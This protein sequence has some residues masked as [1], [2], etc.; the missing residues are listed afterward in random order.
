MRKVFRHRVLR[1]SLALALLQVANYVAPLLVLLHLTR[2]LGVDT[3]GVVAFGMAII[4]I[5]G[6][7]LDY[8]FALSAT[9]KIALWRE[10]RQY[11]GRLVGAIFAIK[12][13]L[14]VFV[15]LVV[16]SFAVF[17]EKY[18]DFSMFF[19]LTLL[20]IFG[21]AFQPLW[22]FS[23]VEQMRYIT[24][25]TISSRVVF[26]ILI[27]LLVDKQPDYLWVPIANGVAQVV[28]M[29]VAI[30]LM[31]QLG[32]QVRWP[33][34][35]DVKYAL[36]IT[37]GFFA[38]RV[39]VATYTNGGVMVLGLAATP[40]V[41][42]IYSVAEQLYRVMQTVF[43]PVSQAMYPYMAKEKNYS[44][45]AKVAGGSAVVALI[46]AIVGFFSA[47]H[48]VPLV[49]G[50]SW[51]GSTAVFNYFLIAINVNVLAVMSGYPLA[52][53]LNNL[54]V[55]NTSV[56]YGSVIYFL[57]VSAV[58]LV[59]QVT[60]IAL[61]IVLLVAEFYVLVHR[62]IVLWPMA[63]AQYFPQSIKR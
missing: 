44:L 45:L 48:L 23:G 56:V 13:A 15:A 5:S 26:V 53:A 42:A 30:R 17:S 41:V 32:Y 49:F 28:A 59:G 36:R 31:Y 55:A 6:V 63:Y 11:V 50:S 1:N 7:V 24:V 43:S 22:L 9:H 60:P 8:G 18:S 46:G 4:Q 35:R 10:R 37:K 27:L 29:L 51:D 61:V 54:K 47:P 57:G 2:V 38:S 3:Y 58:L 25:A 14:F 16:I 12:I 19:F 33:S 34:V 52:A 20:P 40:A 62:A 39:C 21:Q